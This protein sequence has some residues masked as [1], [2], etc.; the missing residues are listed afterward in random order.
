MAQPISYNNPTGGVNSSLDGATG[1]QLRTDHFVKNALIDT[2]DELFFSPLASAIAMPTNMGK[3]IVRYHYMPLLDDRNVNDQGIDAA[4]A[5]IDPGSGN[6]YGSSHDIA[7][8][9]PALPVLT[10]QGGRVNRVGFTRIVKEG[11]LQ[12]MGFF[13][14]LTDESINFDSDPKMKAHIFTEM[15]RGAIRIKEDVLQRDLLNSAGVIVYPGSATQNSEVT[16]EGANPTIVDFDSLIRLDEL[17]TANKCPY[18]KKYLTGSSNTD[19]RTIP[20]ARVLFCGPKVARLLRTMLDFNKTPAFI[21]VEKYASQTT[22][23]NGEIGAIYNF[24]VIQVQNMLYWSE[25]GA[26][27][28]GGNNGYHVVNGKYVIHPLLCVGEDSFNTINFLAGNGSKTFDV[29]E[30]MPGHDIADLANPY[31]TVGFVSIK[32]YYG[33]LCNRPEYIGLIKTVAPV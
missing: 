23:M 22:P 7:K 33:F 15:M 32:W 12:R 11:T 24:R 2:E 19:T 9:D 25:L 14:E 5:T 17:L 26:P 16:A 8:I 3:K 4:G 13:W 27:E 20:Q 31:G 29:I 6:L 21:P 10:E 28:G 30:K 1:R 18:G